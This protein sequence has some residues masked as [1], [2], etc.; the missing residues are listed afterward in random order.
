MDDGCGAGEML[1]EIQNATNLLG[2]TAAAVHT[3]ISTYHI[4]DQV[5]SFVKLKVQQ[6]PVQYSAMLL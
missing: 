5:A 3:T 1:F 6:L 2:T 4:A